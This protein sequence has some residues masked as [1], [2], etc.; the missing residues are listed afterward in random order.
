MIEINIE[1]AQS[2][3][4]EYLEKVKLGEKVIVCNDRMEQF[5]LTSVSPHKVEKSEKRQFG[6]GAGQMTI[7]PSFYEPLP[8]D[9]LAYFNGDRPSE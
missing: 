7:Y 3:L 8:D 4:K 2:H 6:A 1:E 9:I 5:E